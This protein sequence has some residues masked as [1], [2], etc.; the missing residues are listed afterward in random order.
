MRIDSIAL[1]DYRNYREA[2]F[3]FDPG[4]NVITGDNAQGKTNLLESIYLL[5]GARSWRTRFDREIIAFGAEEAS[6]RAG[7]FAEERE[8]TIELRL[9]RGLRRKILKNGV[10]KSPAELAGTVGAVLFSPEDLDLVRAGAAV[11]RRFMDASLGQ[12]RP[13]YLELTGRYNRLYD[14]KSAVLRAWREKPA[15]LDMLGELSDQMCALSARII[16]YRAAFL[17]RIGEKAGEIHREFSGGRETLTLQ[18]KTVSTVADPFAPA[19]EIYEMVRAHQR[20]HERAEL[21]S[22]S[23][24]TGVHKDDLELYLGGVPARQFASQGQARTAALSLKMAERL[25]F[26]EETGQPP[27]LL[28]DDVLS[29]LD[30]ARQEF[31]LQRIPGGQT[32]ITCCAMEEIV[33]R[34]GGKVITIR[35]G[36]AV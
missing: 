27:I 13:R 16:R 14:Q 17:H 15:L 5:S 19:E 28:L 33:S 24:L 22:G 11:R 29:E 8:Q 25:L 20:A 36:R 9:R 12:L 4:V 6:I 35:D 31:V 30:G 3:Q 7:V 10:A 2:D 26:L 23:C 32:F 34:T 18:Y 1:R 21:E